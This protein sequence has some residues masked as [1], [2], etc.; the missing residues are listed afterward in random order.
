ME[1]NAARPEVV[2]EDTP[3]AFGH[4]AAV[5]GDARF[6]VVEV[7]D[8]VEDVVLLLEGRTVLGGD[9]DQLWRSVVHHQAV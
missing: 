9:V 3:V 5:L 2:V 6:R 8:E 4:H 7:P 1:V